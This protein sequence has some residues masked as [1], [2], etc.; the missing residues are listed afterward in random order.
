MEERESEELGSSLMIREE[1]ADLIDRERYDFV[2]FYIAVK[3]I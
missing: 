1:R 2:L 3:A